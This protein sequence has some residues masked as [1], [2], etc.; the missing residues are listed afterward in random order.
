MSDTRKKILRVL[1]SANQATVAELAEAV[2]LSPIA[3][4]HHLGSLQAENLIVAQEVRHGVGRPYYVYKLT[5]A[6]HEQFPQKYVRLTERLLEELKA[7]LPPETIEQLFAHMAE[8]LA[9]EVRPE[10]AG[11]PPEQKID[12]LVELLGEEGFIARWERAGETFVLTGVS[13]P[14][15]HIGQ[16]HPEV[17]HF[18]IQLMTDVMETEVERCSCMIEGDTQCTFRIPQLPP[19]PPGA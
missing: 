19:Q 2:G 7:T 16:S 14:Y 5:E 8:G 1:K 15:I 10:L 12:R 6:G 4:R 17:C 9:A 13:C 3:V 18:D 11:L